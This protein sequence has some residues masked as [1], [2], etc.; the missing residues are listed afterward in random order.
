DLA[1]GSSPDCNSNGVPDEC[2]LAPSFEFSTEVQVTEVSSPYPRDDQVDLDG[3]GDLDIVVNQSSG[4]TVLFGNGDGTFTPRAA[5]YAGK[6]QPGVVL[7]ADFDGDGDIDF[8][9]RWSN[10]TSG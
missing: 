4:Y 3:D 5:G 6:N 2:D 1:S 8:L 7:T 10:P 9:V